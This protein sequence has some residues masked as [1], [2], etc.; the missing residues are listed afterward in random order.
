MLPGT[1]SARSAT[2]SVVP[3]IFSAMNASASVAFF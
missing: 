3:V 1:R 2:V